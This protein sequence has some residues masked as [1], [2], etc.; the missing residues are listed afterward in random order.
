[1]TWGPPHSEPGHSASAWQYSLMAKLGE[2]TA[3]L[4]HMAQELRGLRQDLVLHMTGLPEQMATQMV[5]HASR[6]GLFR[7][8]STVETARMR[9]LTL[10]LKSGLPYVV[11]ARRVA[12]LIFLWG[13]IGT[14]AYSAE[15]LGKMIVAALKGW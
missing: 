4:H 2:M 6:Q 10:L 13:M 3:G 14:G 1:M 15:D 5:L 7:S 12:I 8:K 9:Q 11:L